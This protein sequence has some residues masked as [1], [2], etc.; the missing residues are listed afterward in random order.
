MT[1]K[2]HKGKYENQYLIGID[3][4]NK[5]ALDEILTRDGKP[6]TL[7]DLANWTRVEQ[8]KDDLN[9]AHIY[10]RSTKPFKNKGRD[11]RF[12]ELESKNEVPAIEVKCEH[13]TMF[14]APSIHT[15][16]YPYEVLGVKELVLFD[17]LEIHLDNIFKKYGI[18]YLDQSNNYNNTSSS[19]LP[20]ELRQLV[21]LLEI[22]PDFHFPIPEGSRHPTL[23]SFANSLLIKHKPDTNITNDRLKDFFYEVNE[24]LCVPE[25]LPTD[26]IQQIWK[27]CLKWSNEKAERVKVEGDDENDASTYKSQLTIPLE[28][29]YDDKL[30][31]IVQTLVYDIQK[32]SVDCQLNS[33][34]KPGTR[35]VVPINIKQWPDVKK[36]L[37]NQCTEKG[38]DEPDTLAL[39][40]SLDKNLDKITKHYLEN[41]RKNVAALAEAE[42]RRKHR[43][44]LIK[45]GTEFVKTKYR[46]KTIKKSNEIYVY[47]DKKGVY[48]P[49]GDIVIDQEIH[50]KYE[51]QLN[52]ANIGEI[53]N[54]VRR[55][56]YIAFEEFDS[57]LDIINLKNGLYNWRTKESLPHTPDYYS[58]NQ[59]PIK[60][61][62]EAIPRRFIKFLLEEVRVETGKMY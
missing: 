53:K 6:I 27:D 24:K 9:K 10:I 30:L 8:H 42:E 51:Y 46:F 3:C 15:N 44:D 21:Y 25:P 40:E 47:D 5:K 56:T 54:Y 48:V 49:D 37:K 32:N 41:H 39:L 14:T 58:L 1:G 28:Y 62:P 16:G 50:R 7:H 22:P 59:K 38:I 31:E 4:D 19:K 12:A 11:V 35:L 17:Q 26:E 23:V 20:K 43:L 2:I 34:Y 55:D 60:Y 29:E 36:S 61:N 18:E 52:T 57:N 13:F 33:K 45:E